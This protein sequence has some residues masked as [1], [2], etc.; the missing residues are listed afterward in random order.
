MIIFTLKSEAITLG[1]AEDDPVLVRALRYD[2]NKRPRPFPTEVLVPFVRNRFQIEGNKMSVTLPRHTDKFVEFQEKMAGEGRDFGWLDMKPFK[3]AFSDLRADD[4]LVLMRNATV[5]AQISLDTLFKLREFKSIE[6]FITVL[7]QLVDDKNYKLSIESKDG[8]AAIGRKEIFGGMLRLVS[9][10]QR[11]GLLCDDDNQFRINLDE[12]LQDSGTITTIDLSRCEQSYAFLIFCVVVRKILELRL[13]KKYPSMFLAIPEAA[14]FCPSKASISPDAASSGFSSLTVLRTISRESRLLGVT[15]A[16]DSQR[17][18][19]LDATVLSNI[20]WVVSGGLH[21]KDAA[22]LS[23]NFNFIPLNV[24]AKLPSLQA[25]VFFVQRIGA[26]NFLYPFFG[27]PCQGRHRKA[28]ESVFDW[29]NAQAF[30]ESVT[31]TDTLNDSLRVVI[32]K[33]GDVS[34]GSEEKEE[35][36]EGEF[37]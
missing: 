8:S 30:V 17:P 6:E 32:K 5:S 4:L 37:L 24:R 20:G 23:D 18:A 11:S 3:I 36:E 12:V 21:A 27:A 15:L 7:V 2:H 28:G 29:I 31:Y 26:Q 19:D 13:T 34:V 33:S 1:F 14:N 9:G 35:E 22:W 10:L 16:L 25:G